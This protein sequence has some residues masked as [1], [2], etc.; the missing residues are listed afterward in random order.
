MICQAFIPP[1]FPPKKKTKKQTNKQ[2]NK[3]PPKI[4]IFVSREKESGSGKKK[5]TH[6]P[7]LTVKWFAPLHLN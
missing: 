3:K 5:Q 6:S 1:F 2:T 4:L 7:P